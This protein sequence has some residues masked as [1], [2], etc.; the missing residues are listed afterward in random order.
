MTPIV[1]LSHAYIGGKA[2]FSSRMYGILKLYA[3]LVIRIYCRRVVINQPGFLHSKGPLLLAANHPNSFLDGI[4]LTTLFDRPIRSLARGDAFQHP[5]LNKFL[6]WLNLLPV[7]RTSEGVHNLGHNYTTFDACHDTFEQDGI[8]LIFSEGWCENEWH[9]RPLKKGTARLA[10]T[11]WQNGVPLR[12]LPVALNYSSFKW[13][14]KTVHLNF[15]NIISYRQFN[16]GLTDGKLLLDFNEQLKDELEKLVYELD[17]KDKDAI[18]RVFKK[19]RR[20]MGNALLAVPALI[21]WVLHAIFYYPIKFFC[22]YRFERSGH[23]DSV[24]HSLLVLGYPIFLLLFFLV[25]LSWGF[26]TALV[27]TLLM[28]FFAWAWVQFSEI[29]E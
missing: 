26:L 19:R 28:P 2:L 14:G 3:R 6:R 13:F 1:N 5:Y 7:Y 4:I 29:W 8:V 18:G 27:I 24:L 20:F 17:P 12:V 11:T 10:T 25:V 9:L 15:G 16:P 22:D 23:Y 21:G